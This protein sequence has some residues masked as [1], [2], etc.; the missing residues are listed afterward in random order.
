MSECECVS[1]PG[2][3]TLIFSCSLYL[4]SDDVH[5]TTTSDR[6]LPFGCFDCCCCCCC[7]TFQFHFFF[8][9]SPSFS[10]FLPSLTLLFLLT[11]EGERGS[12]DRPNW[13]P[14]NSSGGGGGSVIAKSTAVKCS[15]RFGHRL[16]ENLESLVRVC[17]RQ[18]ADDTQRL[19]ESYIA[20]KTTKTQPNCQPDYLAN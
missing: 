9:F 14:K 15:D 20:P 12:I 4:S 1:R 16:L 18:T 3:H 17:K 8:S 10:F 6:P 19:S 11:A 13:W 5:S 7:D 2:A